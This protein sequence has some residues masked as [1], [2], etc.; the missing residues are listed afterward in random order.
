MHK[1]MTNPLRIAALLLAVSLL[2]SACSSSS[3]FLDAPEVVGL[4]SIPLGHGAMASQSFGTAYDTLTVVRAITSEVE[5]GDDG[6]RYL[7]TVITLRN[8]GNFTM[9]NLTLLGMAAPAF[10]PQ[11]IAPVFDMRGPLGEVI[12]DEAALVRQVS[13]AHPPDLS[14]SSYQPFPIASQNSFVAFA[15]EALDVPLFNRIENLT[16]LQVAE[17]DFALFPYGF[18]IGNL[19]AGREITTSIG[20]RLPSDL[21]ARSFSFAF[22]AVA[23]QQ[24]PITQGVEEIALAD[25]ED[26]GV[27]GAVARFQELEADSLVLIGSPRRSVPADVLD[28]VVRLE[29]VRVV[30]GFSDIPVTTLLEMTSAAS[31]GLPEVVAE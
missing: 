25:G 8:D 23:G 28:N 7:R 30:G 2:L 17:G 3:A 16:G 21:P 10:F 5:F 9:P 29:D 22:V 6:A 12:D 24:H 26:S 20:F 14:E 19:A 4:G 11:M 31:P 1:K 18:Y 15:E 13:P 27:A